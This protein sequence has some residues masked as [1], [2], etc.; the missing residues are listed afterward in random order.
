[1]LCPCEYGSS[2]GGVGGLTATAALRH[3]EVDVHVRTILRPDPIDVSAALSACVPATLR[4]YEARRRNLTARIQR[5]SRED[6]VVHHADSDAGDN[7]NATQSPPPAPDATPISSPGCTGTTRQ[8]DPPATPF[9][10][11]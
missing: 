11:P 4:R 10:S 2:G 6:N 3:V 9:V 8:P 5:M 7:G 1:M